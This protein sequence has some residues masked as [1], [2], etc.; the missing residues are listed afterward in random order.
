VCRISVVVSHTVCRMATARIS[1]LLCQG[2]ALISAGAQHHRQTRRLV[3]SE[4][5][6]APWPVPENVPQNGPTTEPHN[7]PTTEPHNGPTTEPQAR[8]TRV[9]AA[10]G[11]ATGGA[12]A[13][14]CA[15]SPLLMTAV[16]RHAQ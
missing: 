10:D 7:G 4:S 2:I 5:W 6:T 3:G 12:F 11:Y 15:C 16:H 14:D 9:T 13:A 1:P 8:S